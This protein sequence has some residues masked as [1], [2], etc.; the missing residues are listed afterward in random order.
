MV[1]GI[2]ASTRFAKSC[3]NVAGVSHVIDSIV[4]HA[5]LESDVG[6]ELTFVLPRTA[7]PAFPQLFSTLEASRDQLGISSYGVSVTTM[8]EVFLKVSMQAES[9]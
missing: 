8:E 2:S 3:C 9:T 6:A 7:A 1:C 4:P 5:V